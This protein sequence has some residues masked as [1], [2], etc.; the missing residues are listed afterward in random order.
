MT[1]KSARQVAMDFV[2][3]IN[4]RDVEAICRIMAEE[5]VFVDSLGRTM[6]GRGPMR[7][8]WEGYFRM[9]P[10]YQISIEDVFEA[11]NAVALFGSA[12]GTLSKDGALQP[13]NHWQVPAAWK[14]VVDGSHIAEWRVYADNYQTAKLIRSA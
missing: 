7:S 6:K 3:A 9:F 14:A 10:D 11:G 2:A 1:A 5:F 8:G 13:E 12:Q 4:S